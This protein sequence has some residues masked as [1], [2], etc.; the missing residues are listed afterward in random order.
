MRAEKQLLLDEIKSKIDESTGFIITKYE[1]LTALAANEFRGEISKLESEFEVVRKRIFIKA[2]Q[3]C[4]IKIS[5]TDLEGH[6]GI[7]FSKNDAI[8]TTKTIVDFGKTNGSIFELLGARI[9]GE[10][11]SKEEVNKLAQL[12]GKEQLQAEFLGLL[13]AP[14]ATLLSTME[15]LLSS[16]LYCL[17]NRA[18]KS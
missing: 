15:S 5:S 16:I 10:I 4:D 18:K 17:D 6:I 3:E 12:P 2:A 7:V 8:R 14:M 1:G 13:E 11:Y 9:E